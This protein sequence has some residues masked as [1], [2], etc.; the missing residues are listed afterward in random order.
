MV[1]YSSLYSFLFFLENLNLERIDLIAFG[2]SFT[3]E[4][5][6]FVVSYELLLLSYRNYCYHYIIIVI[7]VIIIIINVIVIVIQLYSLLS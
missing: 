4:H 6:F 5:I 3:T 7:I 1:A 2:K